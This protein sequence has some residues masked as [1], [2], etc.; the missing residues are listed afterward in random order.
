MA[1]AGHPPRLEPRPGLYDGLHGAAHTLH[2]VGRTAQALEVLDRAIDLT[3]D[4][5]PWACT[6]DWRASA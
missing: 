6:T 3:T 2:L 5:T 1:V 4:L